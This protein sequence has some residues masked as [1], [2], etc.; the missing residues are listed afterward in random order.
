VAGFKSLE[1][2]SGVKVCWSLLCPPNI[3]IQHK[4]FQKVIIFRRACSER[5]RSNGFIWREGETLEQISQRGR[6]GPI[7]GNIQGQVGR[8]S[9]KPGLVEDVPAHRRGLG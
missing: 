9:E 6:G 3:C 4:A 2:K 7:L 1:Q 8:G 5:T